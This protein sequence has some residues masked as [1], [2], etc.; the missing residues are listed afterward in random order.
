MT[1]WDALCRGP[2]LRSPAN[3]Y[4]P[5][6]EQFVV[7]PSSAPSRGAIRTHQVAAGLERP[8]LGV[9]RHCNRG[10]TTPAREEPAPHAGFDEAATGG[11][12][13]RALR[14]W[15]L[16]DFGS[17]SW[18]PPEDPD[19]LCGHLFPLAT[20]PRTIVR[21]ILVRDPPSSG[22]RSYPNISAPFRPP[23]H[24]DDTPHHHSSRTTA[25][26]A[27]TPGAGSAMRLAHSSGTLGIDGPGRSHRTP[28]LPIHPPTTPPPTP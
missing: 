11:C 2:R 12:D 5:G 21:F 18:H 26:P 20:L 19:V 10:G 1:V 27:H 28:P 8:T 3:C 23:H 9:G 13:R 15:F 6:P 22:A 17:G 4:R 24:P 7:P 14:R 25:S 16:A